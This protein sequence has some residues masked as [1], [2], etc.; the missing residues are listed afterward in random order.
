MDQIRSTVHLTD[1]TR[2]LGFTGEM[3][4]VLKERSVCAPVQW[5]VWLCQPK[6]APV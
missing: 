3:M 6:V 2:R 1:P 4:I 5:V